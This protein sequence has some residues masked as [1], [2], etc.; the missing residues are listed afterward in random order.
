MKG[1]KRSLLAAW[2]AAC[3]LWSPSAAANY[4]AATSAALAD[5][6]GK[7]A[8]GDTLTVAPGRYDVT[9]WTLS[10]LAG[11]PDK[12][13]V[14]RGEPGAAIRSASGCCNLVQIDNSSYLALQGLELGMAQDNPDID[15]INVGGKYSHHLR[16][17]NLK[18]SGM[19]G[20]G[21]SVFAD[22]ASFLELLRSEIG[23]VTGCG[24]YWGYP[25]TNLVHDALIQG[26]YIH[27]CPSD[28]S[29]PLNYGIQFKGWGYRARILD[30]VLHDV[31]GTTRSALIAYY[32]RKPLAGDRPEDVNIVSGNILW[33]CRNEGITVMS[34]AIVEN[35]IVFSAV[36]GINLQTYGDESFDGTS[37]VENLAVRNNTVFRCEEACIALSGWPGAGAGVSLTGNAAIQGSATAVAISGSPG[38]ARVAGNAAFGKSSLA[39]TQIARGLADW[40]SAAAGATVPELDF[41]PSASSSLKDIV[42]SQDCA[43]TDFNGT[44]RPIGGKCDAGAYEA[45]AG[46]N[47]GWRPQA[48]FKGGAGSTAIRGKRPKSKRSGSV[49]LFKDGKRVWIPGGVS[50]NFPVDAAGKTLIPGP[51]NGTERAA[52]R[53][54]AEAR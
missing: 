5:L 1:S 13:I 51:G 24:L 29:D 26:N 11:K 45:G 23:P 2:C 39:G 25:G 40:V 33:N 14:I 36:V 41:Y 12:W 48:G 37:A 6:S 52:R 9:S 3:G 18:I 7:L 30:N 20:N 35:N 32:G 44:A 28:A 43:T 54:A 8:A 19:T 53:A 47:P 34:D 49:P 27:H 22:S 16:F 46:A 50:E 38:T 17:E 4:R 31:G 42:D 15:G 21:I 10:G